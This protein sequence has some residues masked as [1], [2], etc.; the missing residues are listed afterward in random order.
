MRR[1]SFRLSALLLATLF[2][3][4][5]A[6][7]AFGLGCPHHEPLLGDATAASSHTE[8]SHTESSHAASQLAP[9]HGLAASTATSDAVPQ[10]HTDEAAAAAD[11]A[12]H[13][14]VCT[15]LGDCNGTSG[16]PP[17]S[18]TS[19]R[20]QVPETATTGLLSPEPEANIPGP[21]PYLF[22]PATAPP[23]D[24]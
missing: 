8:S 5:T 18:L 2:F 1:I 12:G 20:L 11:P 23:L 10:L 9:R 17:P 13:D 24:L 21:V 19:A 15:C 22:P 3:V 7:E 16:T 14:Q 6:K 4:S